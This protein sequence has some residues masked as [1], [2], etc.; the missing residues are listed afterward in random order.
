MWL[1]FFLSCIQF[2]FKKLEQEFSSKQ[3][4]IPT[5]GLTGF[6]KE[7]ERE[8]ENKVAI[9]IPGLLSDWS[10]RRVNFISCLLGKRLIR[11]IICKQLWG[12]NTEMADNSKSVHRIIY[13]FSQVKRNSPWFLSPP[14]PQNR[15]PDN[16][17]GLLP[18]SKSRNVSC[19]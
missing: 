3:A 15:R 6:Q 8:S 12:V 19:K 16:R 2:S 7:R 13:S 14:S 10:S 4:A 17:S 11:D 1:L 9:F 18:F 5:A